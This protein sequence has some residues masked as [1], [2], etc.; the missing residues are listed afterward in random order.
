LK[1]TLLG[2][3]V[4]AQMLLTTG[5][6]GVDD[7]ES[8]PHAAGP[9]EPINDCVGCCMELLKEG[10]EGAVTGGTLEEKR[11]KISCLTS[12]F[13]VSAFC[14]CGACELEKSRENRSF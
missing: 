12:F 8:A 5:T 3:E 2:A 11:A 13:V 1:L 14:G 10:T 9:P 6:A 4:F 7:Q